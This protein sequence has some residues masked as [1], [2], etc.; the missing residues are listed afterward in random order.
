MNDKGDAISSCV[1]RFNVPI[2]SKSYLTV[3]TITPNGVTVEGV[4]RIFNGK[5]FGRSN[6]L[7]ELGATRVVFGSR[8]G[9]GTLGKVVR[10]CV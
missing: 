5:V 10:P 9:E 3:R 2:V 6:S 8:R 4:Q 1:G 7:G